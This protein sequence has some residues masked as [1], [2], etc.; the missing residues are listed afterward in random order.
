MKNHS[1]QA[2]KK[3]APDIMCVMYL[4]ESATTTPQISAIALFLILF[5]KI[6]IIAIMHKFFSALFQQVKLFQVQQNL[7]AML[8]QVVTY[9]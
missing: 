3:I 7:K 1:A 8:S 5:L 9:R 4:K 6:M 2:P